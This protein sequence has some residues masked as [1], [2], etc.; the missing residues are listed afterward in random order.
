M[1]NR[2]DIDFNN[3]LL[4]ISVVAF[5]GESEK[6]EMLVSRGVLAKNGVLGEVGLLGEQGT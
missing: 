2:I 3:L 4:P 5:D 6:V 1:S